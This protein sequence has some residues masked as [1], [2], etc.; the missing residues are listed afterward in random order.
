MEIRNIWCNTCGD[1]MVD[2]DPVQNTGICPSCGS[3]ITIPK[4][5]H[6]KKL[7]MLSRANTMRRN[8][9]FDNAFQECERILQEEQDDAEVYW[10]ALLAHFGIEYVQ[11]PSS[12][13]YKPTMH[14]MQFQ[15]LREHEYFGRIRDLSYG[16]QWE[17]YEKNAEKI[18]R[19]S[20]RYMAIMNA[21]PD[22]DVFISYKERDDAGART[23]DSQDAEAIYHMLKSKRGYRVFFSRET[24]KEVAGEEYEPHIFAALNRAKVML[25]Y[26]SDEDY[27]NSTWVKNEWQRYRFLQQ[28]DT[29]KHLIPVLKNMEPDYLP[30]ELAILQAFDYGQERAAEKLL[31]LIDKFITPN[32]GGG[33]GGRVTY[34]LNVVN[35][36]R[37]GLNLI[38]EAKFS[39]AWKTI[40]SAEQ[41]DYTHVSVTILKIAY[42]A[43]A[44][45][46][47]KQAGK[48][49]HFLKAMNTLK[50]YRIKL[51][52][53]GIS[54][55]EQ[56]FYKELDSAEAYAVLTYC[57]DFSVMKERLEIVKKLTRPE[58]LYSPFCCRIYLD[59]LTRMQSW[60]EIDLLLSGSFGTS[61]GFALR[62]ILDHYPESTRKTV[63]IR[64]ILERCPETSFT[65]ND[66]QR[67]EAYFEKSDDS[68]D[69]KFEIITAI[70]KNGLPYSILKTL[71]QFSGR[72][73]LDK[74]IELIDA[75]CNSHMTDADIKIV[76]KYC[77]KQSYDVISAFLKKMIDED[78][79]MLFD[80]EKL[81]DLV[82]SDRMSADEKIK[83]LDLI[84][85]YEKF[86]FD[87][88]GMNAFMQHYVCSGR[89]D[90][91]ERQILIK[92]LL[93]LSD[94]F[95][96]RTVERYVMDCTLDGEYKPMILSMI[97]SKDINKVSL[98]TLIQ[99]Y[100]VSG[101]DS[102]DVAE[103][104]IS[105][106]IQNGFAV[107]DDIFEQMLMADVNRNNINAQK[108]QLLVQN[109]SEPSVKSL[110]I[111]LEKIKPEAYSDEI[112]Q[113]M[114]RNNCRI[115]DEAL[116]SFVLY[117]KEN[118][119]RDK[120]ATAKLL[121]GRNLDSFG[122][123]RCQIYTQGEWVICNLL[124]A[125][126]LLEP[127]GEETRERILRD[128]AEAAADLKN[129]TIGVGTDMKKFKT[130]LMEHKSNI[131]AA[132]INKCK[133]YGI[134]GRFDRI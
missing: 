123:S 75:M 132:T 71:E 118:Q 109:G 45:I 112:L 107:N 86:A 130:Y 83:L 32:M 72:L 11:D 99:K 110:S 126:L 5:D 59:F 80:Y 127:D 29:S 87:K 62:K 104:V 58:Q 67:I 91:E 93:E 23:R 8:K 84:E 53:S 51:L 81:S 95:L 89:F 18:D 43:M 44:A 16:R 66:M 49:E 31:K 13:E 10:E 78:K 70:H 54:E 57:Y 19:I 115:S 25:V 21:Q 117:V 125:Y 128:M 102:S 122:R 124:Q 42:Y 96:A 55:E 7:K 90:S 98:R 47:S 85:N 100:A 65:A 27:I 4:I 73:M 79:F 61:G 40:Q 56:E 41:A 131:S 113:I 105:M 14:R 6:E 50:S 119:C 48:K 76:F 64:R 111:Y 2:Y 103:Q 52:E 3:E 94:Q 121:A 116:A 129:S 114:Y 106:L 74:Q 24:L 28:K 97:L 63:N 92:K 26:G 20:E 9:S 15:E 69:S 60:K 120:A 30:P 88:N 101:K 36:V 17:I 133:T 33:S 35:I 38:G 134:F 22:Y 46:Q 77:V 39:E 108:F 12:G 68:I 37:Q 1:P 34:S 82:E